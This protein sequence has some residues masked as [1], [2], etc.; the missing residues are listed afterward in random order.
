MKNST[1]I[2]TSMTFMR[3]HYKRQIRIYQR[4]GENVRKNE[5]YDR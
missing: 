3:D 2:S 1:G 4:E 5:P